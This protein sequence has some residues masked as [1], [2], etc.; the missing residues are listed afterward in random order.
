[1]TKPYM[2][3]NLLHVLPKRE[4][5]TLCFL[6]DFKPFQTQTLQ[7][8]IMLFQTRGQVSLLVIMHQ[9]QDVTSISM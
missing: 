4:K 9:N 2:N 5:K 3:V 1:M 6:I 8:T 7:K